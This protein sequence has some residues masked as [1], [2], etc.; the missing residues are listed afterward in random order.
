MNHAESPDAP[1]PERLYRAMLAHSADAIALLDG[2]GT[3]GFVTDSI[4]RLTGFAAAE[5]TG[6]NAFEQVHPDDR[7]RVYDAFLDAR[8]H[9][10]VP[11]AVEYRARHKDGSWRHREV[12][13]VNRLDDPDIA[14]VIVNYHDTTARR[15]AEAALE[16]NERLHRSTFDEA[17]IGIAQ[18]SLSGRFLRVNRWLCRL[19][20]YQPEEL[21]R[22]DFMAITHPDEVER[23]VEASRRLI[24]GE[25]DRYEREKRYRRKDGSFVLMKLAVSVHRNRHGNP[26]Y[27]IAVIEEVTERK[28]LEQEL[29]QAH[30]MEAIGRLAGGIA[31]DF[32]NLLTAIAGY[33]DLAIDALKEPQDTPV[34]K[35]VEE[36]R[37]ACR[38]AA[39]L[40][41]QLLVFSRRQILQP[42]IVDLNAVAKRMHGLLRRLIGEHI[43][44]EWQL[45][46]TIDR[47]NV[48]A[49]QIEQVV[50]NLALN[51]RDAMP[52][53]GTL[54]I[55]TANVV[56]DTGPHVMLAISDTGAGIDET[57]REHLF[58]P[59]YTTK[60]PGHG[61]GLGLA[62]VHGIVQQSGGSISV[63]SEPGR[64]TTFTV[65]LPSAVHTSESGEEAGV[66]PAPL[67]GTETILV[68]EDQPD[69][70]SVARETLT[71]HGYAVIEAANAE[72]ALAAALRH[73]TIDLLLTD[74]VMPGMGGTELARRFQRDR[75][76]LPVL[77]MSGYTPGSIE[78]QGALDPQSLL[79][80][81]PFTAQELL[82]KVR[83]L[84][85]RTP[86]GMTGERPDE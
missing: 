47:L 74:V 82:R 36:I 9:P 81:K 41:R 64:G 75:A 5:L 86:S 33:A 18:T 83:E 45:A 72:E 25:L 59:F 17:P 46:A 71:R 44:I 7:Q 35:D 19:L 28:R 43:E 39:S 11:I 58:E 12:I 70:R 54:T 56:A 68:V 15:R 61:T 42:Q 23:D 55:E 29:R 65:L 77:F 2:D 30:K 51:A 40:T 1:L 31:H 80:Q 67:G 49:G 50:L 84:L 73:R 6:R 69:V 27:F 63:D 4:E 16:E 22:T 8:D 10:G 13:G 57:I 76:G 53:G 20:G 24:T 62:T 48:D 14:A 60:Q 79:I 78:Q 37:A 21:E 32:N 34:R 38:S 3:I 85:D 52:G 66:S 26:V